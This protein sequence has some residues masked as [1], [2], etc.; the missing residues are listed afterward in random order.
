MVKTNHSISL[1]TPPATVI[2]ED[3]CTGCGLC[4]KV[5][6]AKTLSILK[7]KARVTGPHSLRCGH[8]AAVC[9][10]GAV[11]VRGMDPQMDTFDF[12]PSDVDSVGEDSQRPSPEAVAALMRYRRSCRVYDQRRVQKSLLEDLVKIGVTAP[13]GTN[14]QPWFFI[15]LEERDAVE[16][17]GK[18]V[19][20]FYRLLNRVSSMRTARLV[21][22]FLPGDPLGTYYREFYETVKD[23]LRDF[24]RFGRDRLF[25]EAPACILVGAEE[26]ASTPR[27]DALLATQNIILA[28][29]SLGLGTCLIGLAVEAVRNDPR[30]QRRLGL[31]KGEK[32]HSVIALGYPG[33]TYRRFAGRRAPV[34]KRLG[35]V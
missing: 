6:P 29:E 11:F 10:E 35:R 12:I 21:S 4:V 30:L 22:R 8:C 23:G 25:H 15:L 3:A 26:N 19:A 20:K 13:S 1:D 33:V 7:G 18:G 27:E 16:S 32:I 5:C 2:D 14:C 34:I 17:L 9:P 28:A 31:N 24:E